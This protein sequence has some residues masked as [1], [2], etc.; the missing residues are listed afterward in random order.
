LIDMANSRGGHD[1]I[2]V[3][4]LEIPPD[5]DLTQPLKNIVEMQ[6][7]RPN[8][9]LRSCLGVL[10]LLA[11]LTLLGILLWKYW[12]VMTKPERTPTPTPTV[13]HSVIPILPGS[14]AATPT[15]TRRTIASPTAIPSPTATPTQ[16]KLLPGIT[17]TPQ[18][19]STPP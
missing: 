18:P 12:G 1:N 19:T 11:L 6:K 9:R 2:T 5:E 14:A 13:T 4:Y 17:E 10:L 7:K 15:V 8:Q 3:I 16:L